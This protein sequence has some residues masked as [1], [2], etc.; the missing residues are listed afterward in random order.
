MNQVKHGT[1]KFAL[2]LERLMNQIKGFFGDH[3]WLSNFWPS[4]IVFGNWRFPTVEH[5]YQA[6]KSNDPADWE[7]IIGCAT[8]GSAKA[9]GRYVNLRPDWE[10]VKLSV[11]EDLTRM[12]YQIPELNQKLLATGDAVI[13]EDNH[14]GD[15]FWGVCKGQGKNHLGLIIMKIRKE[16]Q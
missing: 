6:A 3:R 4:E 8:P 10:E 2:G 1:D 9:E 15:R 11:M 13:I 5:A 16:L 12:K 7:R 14:W